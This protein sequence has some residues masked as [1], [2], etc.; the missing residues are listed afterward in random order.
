VLLVRRHGQRPDFCF[1][2]IAGDLAEALQRLA[3]PPA[4]APARQFLPG[5]RRRLFVA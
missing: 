4:A 3:V 1:A 5:C 2:E